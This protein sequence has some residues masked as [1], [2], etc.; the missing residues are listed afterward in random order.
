M[1]RDYGITDEETQTFDNLFATTR[2]P[3]ELAITVKTGEGELKRGTMLELDSGSGHYVICATP[4]SLAGMLL[5]DVDATDEAVPSI[6]GFDLDR[7]GPVT[8]ATG[9]TATLLNI[10]W[11]EDALTNIVEGF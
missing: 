10:G 7:L 6:M 2:K 8:A 4:S 3:R 11:Y 9:F 5:D 1:A